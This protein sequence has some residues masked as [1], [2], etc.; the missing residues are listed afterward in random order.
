MKTRAFAEHQHQHCIDDALHRAREIC[1]LRQAQLTPLRAKI[2]ELVWSSHKPLG[3]YAL[4]ELLSQA[5]QQEEGSKTP[6]APPT[7]YRALEFLQQQGLVHRVATL[8][9]FIGCEHPAKDHNSCFFICSECHQT[10]EFPAQQL[11]VA[12]DTQAR[13][14]G[15]LVQRANV[16]VL[17][18]CPIC[19]QLG[20]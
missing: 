6:V 4:M 16:E 7:V 18:L 5:R 13:S 1:Q 3:A 15:F 11:N 2:L 9:A 10:E 17:G 20:H 12:I 19:Q 8:N 14:S